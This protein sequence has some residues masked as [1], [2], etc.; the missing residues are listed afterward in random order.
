MKQGNTVFSHMPACRDVWPMSGRKICPKIQLL[1]IGMR[2][3]IV[4]IQQFL[5]QVQ[6]KLKLL[7]LRAGLLPRHTFSSTSAPL[8]L[9]RGSQGQVVF[10]S[11]PKRGANFIW[12]CV[13]HYKIWYPLLADIQR[14][15]RM[16]M[17]SPRC[18]HLPKTTWRGR[19]PLVLFSFPT[20]VLE[21]C[22]GRPQG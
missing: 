3:I 9:C 17:S 11:F 14:N 7:V 22:A 1:E 16:K 4:K 6:V 10:P 19:F 8:T 18:L 13:I 20:A 2:I 12:G 5:L 21:K 15:K